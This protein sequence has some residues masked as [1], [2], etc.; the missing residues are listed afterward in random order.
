MTTRPVRRIAAVT[1][2]V[3]A[4][5]LGACLAAVPSSAGAQVAALPFEV[6]ERLEC[7]VSV[8]RMG[9]IG[10]GAMWVDGIADVRGR[11]TMVLRF[12]LEAG[13]EPVRGSD[14]TR[15]WLD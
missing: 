6:G 5:T 11:Q 14:K 10:K 3:H 9:N 13:K 4:L 7:R 15:S 8:G 2:A 12:E 1:F